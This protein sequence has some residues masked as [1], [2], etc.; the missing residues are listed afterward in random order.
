MD[1]ASAILIS[2]IPL[3]LILH[4]LCVSAGEEGQKAKPVLPFQKQSE[5]GQGLGWR[6]RFFT[7]VGLFLSFFFDSKEKPSEKGG[8][9]EKGKDALFDSKNVFDFRGDSIALQFQSRR[10]VLEKLRKLR[11]IYFLKYKKPMLRPIKEEDEEPYL[12]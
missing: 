2:Q 3:V 12:K 10:K 6:R 9:G 11:Q 8:E 7:Y 1:Y 4:L 5:A